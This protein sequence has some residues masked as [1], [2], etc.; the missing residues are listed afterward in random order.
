MGTLTLPHAIGSWLFCVHLC[1]HPFHEPGARPLPHGRGSDKVHSPE[2][3]RLPITDYLQLST[4]NKSMVHDLGYVHLCITTFHEPDPLSS[5]SKS[6]IPNKFQIQNHKPS[7]LGSARARSP[8]S[9]TSFEFGASNLF[10][11][12]GFSVTQVHGL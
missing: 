3:H 8:T 4:F 12:S 2:P 1:I 11:I 7:R 5:N 6:Q 10:G 9:V